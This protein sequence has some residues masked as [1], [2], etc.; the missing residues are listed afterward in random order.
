MQVRAGIY[1]RVSTD[2]QKDFGYSIDDQIR[3]LTSFCEKNSFAIVGIYNDAGHSAKDLNRPY[4]IKLIEDIKSRK[5]DAVVALKLDRLSRD[6]YDS[7]WFKKLCA[8]NNCDIYL[9]S[10][11]YDLTTLSGNMMY[12]ITSL[13]AE[14]ERKEIGRRTKRGLEEMVHQ[15]RHPNI[16]PYGYIRNEETGKLEID[17]V[18]SLVVKEIYEMCASGKSTRSIANELQKR[19]YHNFGKRAESRVYTILANPIYTGTFHYGRT[20]RKKEDIIVIENYCEPIINPKLKRQAMLGLEKNKHPN[21]GT[22]VHLFSSLIRCPDCNKILSS[23]MSYKYDK[24]K[25]VRKKYFFL[26]CRNQMC[27]SKGTYYNT[28]KLEEK[29]IRVLKELTMISIEEKGSLFKPSFSNEDEVNKIEVAIKKLEKQEK[30]LMDLYMNSNIN[31]EMINDQN[32]AIKIEIDRLKEIH[33]ELTKERIEEEAPDIFEHFE[34]FDYD[35]PFKIDKIWEFISPR[36]KKRIINKYIASIDINRNDDYEIDIVNINFNKDYFEAN[37]IDYLTNLLNDNYKSIM[38]NPEPITDDNI[39]DIVKDNKLISL[40]QF[41]SLS[42]ENQ[43]DICAEI[44]SHFG[45]EGVEVRKHIIND[46]VIDTYFVL[47]LPV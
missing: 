33:S 12:G 20:A 2:E 1:V 8:E 40:S 35:N 47:P 11:N 44:L 22:H 38:I 15:K 29:L 6:S 19:D 36:V 7:Q 9:A 41:D 16:A 31:V 24:N 17:P 42:N 10:E 32:N 39:L 26:Y 5:I 25:K 13:F 14:H 28:G 46:Q 21:Y 3:E 37:T 18:T 23:S 4:M 45:N 30:R 34:K 27:S 43:M